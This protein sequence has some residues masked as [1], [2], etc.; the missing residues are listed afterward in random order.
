VPLREAF[1]QVAAPAAELS[2]EPA[3]TI[4]AAIRNIFELII[5]LL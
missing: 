4:T 3:R 1:E 5:I 2:A